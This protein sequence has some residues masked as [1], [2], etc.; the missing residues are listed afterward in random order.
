ML[1]W[2]T[3]IP[4]I[5]ITCGVILLL[6][7]I[8]LFILGNKK[9]KR[10]SNLAM[11]TG[12]MNQ[13]LIND[14][15]V[16][17]EQ[18]PMIID[19][20]KEINMG[21]VNPANPAIADFTLSK[22]ETTVEEKPAVEPVNTFN[23]TAPAVEAAPVSENT[24]VYDFSIPAEIPVVE[25]QTTVEPTPVVDTT[26]EVTPITQTVEPVNTFNFTAPAV[27][28]APVSENTSVYDFSIP[29]EIPVVEEHTTVEPT[30]VVDT[31]PV[32]EPVV[33]EI[34]PVQPEVT[35]YGGND[36]LVN[37]Q[38]SEPVTHEPY[39]G[40]PA[41]EPVTPAVEPVNTFNFTAPTT[42]PVAE[43]PKVNVMPTISIP[44]IQEVNE[45]KEEL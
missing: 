26:P 30:P 14:E 5:L 28:A 16:T 33:E 42:A 7:A 43:E 36:P 37:T 3:T 22:T 44:E 21:G 25:E 29:T 27:E 4:G 35:I 10:T 17:K 31:T 34:K 40:T 38:V 19:E 12:V 15:V 1:D 9:D 11:N 39:M 24:S 41:L 32:S 45:T 18:A 13:P 20:P 2:I 23:F 6:I 8:V